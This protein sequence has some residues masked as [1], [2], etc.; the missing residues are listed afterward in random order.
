[1]M[2]NKLCLSGVNL[3][4]N[5]QRVLFRAAMKQWL[6]DDL[7]AL[8][9]RKQAIIHLFSVL[10]TFQQPSH[11]HHHHHHHHYHH[12]HHPHWSA[13]LTVL[14]GAIG[15]IGT[16]FLCTRYTRTPKS[17]TTTARWPSPPSNAIQ[18]IPCNYW[19]MSVVLIIW[20]LWCPFIVWC[21]I[22]ITIAITITITITM[23]PPGRSWW[24]WRA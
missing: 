17:T 11:H 22:N 19:W 6:W 20:S 16:S 13:L 8:E 23:P 24:I 9:V 7:K 12:R 21:P 15:F 10:N 4:F 2:L 18:T 3:M 5:N 1:M 14:A